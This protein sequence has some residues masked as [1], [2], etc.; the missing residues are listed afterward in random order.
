[1]TRLSFFLVWWVRE[2]AKLILTILHLLLTTLLGR[3]YW[4][5]LRMFSLPDSFDTST[6]RTDPLIIPFS[7]P[8]SLVSSPF[9]PPYLQTIE[10]AIKSWTDEAKDYNP[11][12]PNF[13]HFTQVSSTSPSPS[14]PPT[15][16]LA[17]FPLSIV[18]HFLR[19]YQVVWKGT[20]QVG[21]AAVDCDGIF[22]ASFGVRLSFLFF[23]SSYLSSSK[24]K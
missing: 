9:L 20:T 15:T 24:R 16:S 23:L 14:H 8:P 5:G 19:S 22:D 1:M 3:W 11:S 4:I 17:L 18:D 12:A 10:S 21:C 7:F 13:S 6:R 2:R